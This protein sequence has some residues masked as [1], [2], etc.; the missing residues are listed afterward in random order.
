MK[1]LVIGA[2]IGGMAT[3]LFLE[4]KGFDVALIERASKLFKEKKQAY[5][6]RRIAKCFGGEI[7]LH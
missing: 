2:G 4:K 3:F 5:K 1:I 7:L 6:K